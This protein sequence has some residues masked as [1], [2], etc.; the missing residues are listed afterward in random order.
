MAS[1]PATGRRNR[2]RARPRRRAP[3]RRTP[4]TAY[5]CGRLEDLDFPRIRRPDGSTGFSFQ[6]FDRY[7]RRTIE[8]D[9]AIGRLVIAGVSTRKLLR[10]LQREGIP[11]AR[12]TTVSDPSALRAADL[13]ARDFQAPAPTWLWVADLTYVRTW[14]GYAYVA[15]INDA[16]SRSIVGWQ[17]A[18]SLRT[19][20]ALD[21]LAQ[22]LWA[23]PGPFDGLVHHSD[24][25]GPYRSFRYMKRLAEAGAVTSVGSRG[26]AYDNALA[27]SVIGLYK[28]E[29]VNCRGPWRGV[30]DLEL[31]TLGWVD[32]SNDRRL[33]GAIGCVPPAEYEAT[34]Y[35]AQVQAEAG[36]Q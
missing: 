28:A 20:L 6:T 3:P 12:C 26:D 18:Q 4:A 34:P 36:T 1:G 10:Q 5:G 14:S 9:T 7:R 11:V 27:E 2:P 30:A 16:C 23:R 19:D 25:G 33:F 29:L 8:L 17:V 24:R 31:A 35:R 22:A 13:V 21:A 15:M 32:C